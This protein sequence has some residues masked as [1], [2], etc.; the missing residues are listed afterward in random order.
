MGSIP[1]LGRYPGEGK[2]NILQYFCLKNPMDRVPGGLQ[3]MGLQE[4]DISLIS[5]IQIIQCCKNIKYFDVYNSVNIRAC[6]APLSMGFPRQEHWN[7]LP[8]PSP[9]DL[10]PGIEPMSPALQADSLLTEPSG[11]PYS[12][13]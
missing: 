10:D 4:S 8:F 11:K 1:G 6:Q 5:L 13:L 7:G 3:S 12:I 9:G 2:G